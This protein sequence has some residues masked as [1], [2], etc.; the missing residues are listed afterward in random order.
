MIRI[1]KPMGL[2]VDESAWAVKA[3]Y[4]RAV[5]TPV[6]FHL[7]ELKMPSAKLF[8]KSKK[9]ITVGRTLSVTPSITIP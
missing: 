9:R 8:C 7:M 6:L 3:K 1:K 2:S 4:R 5:C